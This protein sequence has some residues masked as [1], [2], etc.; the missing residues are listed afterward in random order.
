MV[1]WSVLL[2]NAVHWRVPI[3]FY[4]I[5]MTGM[6]SCLSFIA[7]KI[8]LIDI[9]LNKIA[10]CTLLLTGSWMGHLHMVEHCQR[11]SLFSVNGVENEI[12]GNRGIWVSGSHGNLVFDFRFCRRKG[13]FW[14]HTSYG[15]DLNVWKILP[16]IYRSNCHFYLRLGLIFKRTYGHDWLNWLAMQMWNSVDTQGWH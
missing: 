2:S 15:S 8:G 9:E 5:Q 4:T 7:G 10:L 11:N 6:L 14:P 3:L 12:C 13:E 1:L 16:C